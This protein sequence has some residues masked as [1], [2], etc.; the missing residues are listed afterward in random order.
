MKAL[1]TGGAGF[2]GSHLVDALVGEGAEVRVLD[3]LSAGR[4]EDVN[5]KADLV[6]GSVADEQ[7]VRKA[8]DKVEVVFHQAA[9]RAVLQSVEHP[10]DTDSTNVH[11]TLTV[12][13]CAREAKVQRVVSASSSS[14]YGNS[15]VFPTSEAVPLVPRSPYAVSKLAGEH[16]CRVFAETFGME[17]VCLRYFNAYG[18]RQRP[19]SAYAAVIP[20]FI[21]A[22]SN[23]RSPTV[24][25]D[26]LQARDFTFIE[27]VVQANLKAAV[28]PAVSC[29]GRAFNIA[30][31]ASY[32]LMELLGIL[33]ELLGTSLEPVHT[34]ER[35]G[36]IRRSEADISAARESLGYVP[37]V[38]FREGLERTVRWFGSR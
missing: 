22:L 18:P 36:D 5:P 9:R 27:D 1:V 38:G 35:P 3:D 6:V 7:V 29:S 28:A 15:V 19:D 20:L 11:G 17:T 34:A 8:V 4:E 26:G 32:S 21:D 37:Q 25:G 24:H 2:I 13:Q 14:V 23:G 10:L 30:G 31:G 16:Y 33:Q 12:L